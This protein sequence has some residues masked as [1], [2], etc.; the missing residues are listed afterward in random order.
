MLA[1]APKLVLPGRDFRLSGGLTFGSSEE[2][3]GT[4]IWPKTDV[5]RTVLAL[6]RVDDASASVSRIVSHAANDAGGG[7]TFS[8]D[9]SSKRIY[10]LVD[11][12]TTD[13]RASRHFAPVQNKWV[14]VL[15]NLVPPNSD[16]NR[17]WSSYDGIDWELLVAAGT[18][19]SGSGSVLTTGTTATIG[20]DSFNTRRFPGCLALVAIWLNPVGSINPTTIRSIVEGDFWGQPRPSFLWTANGD[21]T[22][23]VNRPSSLGGTEVFTGAYTFYQELPGYLSLAAGYTHPTL[24][25]A[26]LVPASGSTYQPRVTYTF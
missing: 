10:F 20:S 21:L 11:Y 1:H 26:T 2:Y 23:V 16:S 9:P 8:I 5:P 7:V 3:F 17:I 14:W 22:E 18:N 19:T 13:L 12:T 24:S 4:N 15:A 25:L 6:M